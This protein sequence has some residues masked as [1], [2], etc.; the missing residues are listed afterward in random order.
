MKTNQRRYGQRYDAWTAPLRS[1]P[2]LVC[3]LRL[4]NQG[5]VGVFYLA[6][7]LLLGWTWATNPWKL[8]PL[9]GVVAAGFAAVSLFRKHRNAPRP[10]E[11]CD[12]APLIARDGAGR[13]FPSRHAFSA[14]AIAASWFAVSAPTAAAL[15]VA[16]V[17]LALCRVLGGVHFPRDVI[18]GGLLGTAVGAL[19]AGLASL[20]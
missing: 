5:L 16:A 4:V 7:V 8:V 9:A 6:Y 12:M 18:V 10:Y 13:S 19:A 17:L 14:F 11:C 15:L 1:R 20:F 2:F 3:G